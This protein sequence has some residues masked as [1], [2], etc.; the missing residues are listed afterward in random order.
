MSEFYWDATGDVNFSSE[1]SFASGPCPLFEIDGMI[2]TLSL[3]GP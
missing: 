3:D 1:E 2:K